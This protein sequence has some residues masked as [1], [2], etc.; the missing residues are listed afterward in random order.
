MNKL[1]KDIMLFLKEGDLTYRQIKEI[2]Q[3]G[4]TTLRT[5]LKSM[6]VDGLIS[7]KEVWMGQANAYQYTLK[8]KDDKPKYNK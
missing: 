3:K 1:Q 5:N 2:T 7:F 8:V 6:V 4:D